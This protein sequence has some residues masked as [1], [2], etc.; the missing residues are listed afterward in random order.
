M[1]DDEV[2]ELQQEARAF[3]QTRN[4]VFDKVAT[5]TDKD[6]PKLRSATRAPYHP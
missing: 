6:L 3:F 2:T 4:A 5:F 1:Y